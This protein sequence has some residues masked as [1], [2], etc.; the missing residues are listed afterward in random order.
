MQSWTITGNCVPVLAKLFSARE[1]RIIFL[2][3]QTGQ[4][5]VV[6]TVR[7]DPTALATSKDMNVERV[8]Y[9]QKTLHIG[10]ITAER[11]PIAN[12][13]YIKAMLLGILQNFFDGGAHEQ[14]HGKTE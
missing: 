12:Q 5:C 3:R 9:G 13:Q 6:A 11:V 4:G 14:R 8:Q 1:N 7:L 2:P 10:G